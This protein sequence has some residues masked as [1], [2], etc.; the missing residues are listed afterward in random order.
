MCTARPAIDAQRV[1]LRHALLDAALVSSGLLA[2]SHKNPPP[3]TERPVQ[4]AEGFKLLAT[5]GVE[6]LLVAYPSA[7]YASPYTD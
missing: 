3:A 6:V 4:Q 5:L 7:P 1:V 2:P